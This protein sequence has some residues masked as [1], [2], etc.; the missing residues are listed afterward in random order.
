MVESAW[1]QEEGL[2]TRGRIG[3]FAASERSSLRP[4]CA[5]P[6]RDQ[7]ELCAF[8]TVGPTPMVNKR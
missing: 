6:E 1:K 5:G 2:A 3:L 4:F 8:L 7:G